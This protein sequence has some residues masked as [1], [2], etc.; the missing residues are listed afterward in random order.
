MPLFRFIF[1]Q[2]PRRRLAPLTNQFIGKADFCGH[3]LPHHF[4]RLA[5]ALLQRAYMQSLRI[6]LQDN[7]IFNAE[8]LSQFRWDF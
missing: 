8:I 7:I 3:E 1:G 5:N 6:A 2:F 4:L